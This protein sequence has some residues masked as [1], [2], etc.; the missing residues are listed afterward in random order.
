M[1]KE[2]NKEYLESM[3]GGNILIG[4]N[5]PTLCV[6]LRGPGKAASLLKM[7][8]ALAGSVCTS[9]RRAKFTS[10]LP[11]K[12]QIFTKKHQKY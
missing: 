6:L 3:F 8:V 2:I 4:M 9:L 10:F 12:I 5:I 1:V 7:E 11:R